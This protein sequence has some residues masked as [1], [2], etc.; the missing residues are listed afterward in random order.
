MYQDK[1]EDGNCPS[2]PDTLRLLR[3]DGGELGYGAAHSLLVVKNAE[4]K[5]YS[6]LGF[7]V[8]VVRGIPGKLF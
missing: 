6:E 7:R 8:G 4:S 5:I 3:G 1:K 2:G